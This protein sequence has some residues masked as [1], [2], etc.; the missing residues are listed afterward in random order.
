M[1]E[2]SFFCIQKWAGGAA[3]LYPHTFLICKILIY[4]KITAKTQ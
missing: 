4:I 1:T 3:A 2:G